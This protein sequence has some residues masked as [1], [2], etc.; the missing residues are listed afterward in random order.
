MVFKFEDASEEWLR[1][2]LENHEE[3]ALARVSKLLAL[4]TKDENGCLVTDTKASRKIRFRGRQVAAYRFIYCIL[5]KTVLNE[6]TVVRHRCHN[7]RCCHPEHL[8]EGTR[9]DN[10]R[11]DWDHWANG[12]DYELL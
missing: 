1:D 6:D 10:Q 5:N 11:D 12:T 9:A 2:S 7:R 4:T 8:E 3:E